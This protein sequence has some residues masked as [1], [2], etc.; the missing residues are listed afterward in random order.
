MKISKG[1]TQAAHLSGAIDLE[2]E[3][4]DL[5][6]HEDFPNLLAPARPIEGAAPR[7]EE[8]GRLEPVHSGP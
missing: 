7:G 1:P 3:A 8:T 5:G 2:P 6:S 4:P